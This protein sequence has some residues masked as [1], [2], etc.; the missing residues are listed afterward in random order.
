M[1]AS[2]DAPSIDPV[3][4][5]TG[6]LQRFGI[7]AL[8]LATPIA[9]CTVDGDLPPPIR[10]AFTVEGQRYRLTLQPEDGTFRLRVHADC[11]ILPYTAENA[12]ARSRVLRALPR[13]A[14]LPLAKVGVTQRQRLLVIGEWSIDGPMTPH[15]VFYEVLRF[16]AEARPAVSL[17]RRLLHG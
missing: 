16:M 6:S 13:I 3:A 11:G 12:E 5:V 14:G 2:I 1:N 10:S 15:A 17:I 8:R 9:P 7:A 4:A